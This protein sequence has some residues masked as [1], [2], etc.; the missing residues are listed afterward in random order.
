MQRRHK[1]IPKCTG[2]RIGPGLRL[3]GI[4]MTGEAFLMM[5]VYWTMYWIR[6]YCWCRW[7]S[8]LSLAVSRRQTL[9][10]L[11]LQRDYRGELYLLLRSRCSILLNWDRSTWNRWLSLRRGGFGLIY[12]SKVELTGRSTRRSLGAAFLD[13]EGTSTVS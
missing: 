6:R 9:F 7:L 8:R 4:S 12:C 13:W 2:E 3:A 5:T 11:E 10:A 1:V